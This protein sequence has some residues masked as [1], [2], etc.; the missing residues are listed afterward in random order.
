MTHTL[1]CQDVSKDG[2]RLIRVTG[3]VE[4]RVMVNQGCYRVYQHVD[5]LLTRVAYERTSGYDVVTLCRCVVVISYGDY[6]VCR[7]VAN[8]GYI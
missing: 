8:Q 1:C 6:R 5:E 4:G 3:C 7:R 2:I